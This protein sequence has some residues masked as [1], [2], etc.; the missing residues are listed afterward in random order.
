MGSGMCW[1]DAVAAREEGAA[2][3]EVQSWWSGR[4][5]KL[6]TVIADD[7]RR[8][9]QANPHT[10]D[11]RGDGCTLS[12]GGDFGGGIRRPGGGVSLHA[13]ADQ[14]AEAASGFGVGLVAAREGIAGAD[15]S[16]EED[17]LSSAGEG[18]GCR[19]WVAG[20]V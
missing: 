13:E 20:G 4:F 1:E 6:R 16:G 9:V 8:G 3:L 15:A 7:A 17:E 19:G 2:Q 5:G 18:R 11:E 10:S 12:R 14:W